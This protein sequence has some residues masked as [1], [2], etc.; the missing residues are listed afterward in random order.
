MLREFLFLMGEELVI[1]TKPWESKVDRELLRARLAM[2]PTERIE[3]V[4]GPFPKS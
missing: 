1:E 4:L 2:T 3:T